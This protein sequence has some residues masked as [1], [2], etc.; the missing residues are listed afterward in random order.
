MDRHS[1]RRALRSLRAS[2][3]KRDRDKVHGTVESRC[4]D[5]GATVRIGLAHGVEM[6]AGEH[7]YVPARPGWMCFLAT[8]SSIRCVFPDCEG[9]AEIVDGSYEPRP[10]PVVAYMRIPSRSASREMAVAG[11]VEA[12]VVVS[13]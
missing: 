7:G 9:D 8:P 6:V 3:R 10:G 2:Y 11:V 4:P 12:Q 13:E 1:A 5:C